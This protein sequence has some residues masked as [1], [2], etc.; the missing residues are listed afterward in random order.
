MR[1]FDGVYRWFLFRATPSLDEEGKIIKWYGTNTD[2]EER[3]RAEQALR[4]SEAYLAEAQRLTLTGSC[5]IDG[6]SQQTVYWSEEMFRIFGLDP[7]QGLPKWDQWLQHVHSDD[8]DKVKLAD[9]AVELG[10]KYFF[11]R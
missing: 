10:A 9:H 2:I 8:R 7:Q 1:R 4:R 11:E 5:A 3:K 6:R